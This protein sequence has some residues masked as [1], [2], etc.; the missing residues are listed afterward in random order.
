MLG[1]LVKV[2]VRDASE[3]KESLVNR[4]DLDTRR[5]VLQY[6][7]DSLRHISIESHIARED[8]NFVFLNYITDFE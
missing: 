6:P 4:I 2:Y 1:V 3:V 7:T 5:I 8:G